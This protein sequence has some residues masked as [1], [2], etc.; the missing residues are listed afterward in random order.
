[1]DPSRFVFLDETGASTNM[2]RRYG[3]CPRGERLVD[4]TPWGHWKTTTF[5]AGLRANGV[6]AP[7]VLD[8]PMTGDVFRAYVE[9]MLAPALSPDDVV[10]MDNLAA[11]KVAGVRDPGGRGERAVPAALLAR[12][13]PHRA[14]LRQAEGD[15]QISGGPHQGRALG[16]DRPSASR[17][18]RNRVPQLPRPLRVRIHLNRIRSR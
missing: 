5:V 7:F 14:T 3:R 12:P 11:H 2:V 16:H 1:M 13:Q 4:A 9:Q 17:L 10:V 15:A 8:G 6:I 18:L